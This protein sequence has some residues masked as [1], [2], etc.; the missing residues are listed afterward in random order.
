MPVYIGKSGDLVGWHR[1][2]TDWQTSEYRA[3][4]LVSSIKFK[5]SHAIW[6]KTKQG[7]S[8]W[9]STRWWGGWSWC[10]T[11]SPYLLCLV[12]SQTWNLSKKSTQSDFQAKNFTPSISP[13]FNSFSKKKHKKWV[14]MEKFTP[15]AKIL[16]CR[17]QW[18]HGHRL[19]ICQ[20]IY[21]TR[22]FG[23]KFYTLKVRKS[24][25]FLLKEK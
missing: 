11:Q 7:R 17:R 15:L 24:R 23:Q 1:C 25:L 13:N 5:L 6:I 16:Y 14:K 20:K 19:E 4:Q 10:W 9:K 12:Q 2:L 3:T 21:T 8:V 18:R 22:F